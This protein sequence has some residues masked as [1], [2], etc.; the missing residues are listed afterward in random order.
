VS[1][2]NKLQ[3]FAEMEDFPH[4]IQAAFDEVFQKDYRLKGR[5]FCMLRNKTKIPSA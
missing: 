1:K 4:V 5:W 2:K 3:R